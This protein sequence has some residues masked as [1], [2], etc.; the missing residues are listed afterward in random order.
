MNTTPPPTKELDPIL[1]K[2]LSE[3][4]DIDFLRGEVEHLYQL[5]DDIDTASDMFKPCDS[6]KGSFEGF[7]NYAM[8]RQ[9]HKSDCLESDGYKLY[10]T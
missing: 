5:L 1:G 2:P 10:L 8:R 7:Y 9:A 4:N 3:C 6:N